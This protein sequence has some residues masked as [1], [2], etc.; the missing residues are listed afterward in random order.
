VNGKKLYLA[1]RIRAVLFL[2]AVAAAAVTHNISW[3]NYDDF[4]LFASLLPSSAAAAAGCLCGMSENG[5][6][7]CY[8]LPFCDFHRSLQNGRHTQ[9]S[10]LLHTSHRCTPRGFFC[11]CENNHFSSAVFQSA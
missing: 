7:V 11:E 8:S 3:G 5:V 9:I 6:C 10:R 2:R 4:S 1:S